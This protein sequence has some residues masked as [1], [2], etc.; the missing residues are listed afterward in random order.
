[1]LL[2]LTFILFIAGCADQSPDEESNKSTKTTSNTQGS[3]NDLPWIAT[4]NTTRINTNDPFKAAAFVSRTLW[5]ATSD[6]NR[7]GGLVLVNPD[8]W[9]IALAST[10][11]IHFPNNGPVLFTNKDNIPDITMNELERLKPTGSKENNGVQVILVGD[12][13]EKVED[14]VKSAGYKVDRIKA[15]SPAD[16]AKAIDAYYAKVSKSNPESVVVGSMDSPEYTIP[17]ANWISHMPEPLL[18]VRKDQVPQETIDALQTRKG[19]ANIYLIG[20]DSVVS[21]KVE[22]ELQQ[23]GKVTRISGKDPYEN[24]IAFAKFKDKTTQFGWGITTPGHNLS[25]I[26]TGS[27]ELAIAA[28]PFSHAGKHAPMI[29]TDKDQMPES[30][31]SYVMSIQPKYKLSPSEG[32]YNHA[33]VTGNE[34]LLT[35]AAQGEIDSMLEIVSESGAGHGGMNMG[36]MDMD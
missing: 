10:D 28:A 1:M 32:P 26:P 27:K 18:Y 16:Y 12:F 35:P 34:K 6:M 7:P 21:S 31:M 5:P 3:S 20:P 4:K 36:G 17:A 22:Q 23:Y 19:K 33:W 25:F 15:E 11:L 9:Q 8:E 2:S 30:V 24:S 14:Q 13:D 29:W